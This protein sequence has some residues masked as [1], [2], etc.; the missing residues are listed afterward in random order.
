MTKYFII[1]SN[2]DDTKSR[3]YI[4]PEHASTL[5]RRAGIKVETEE[6]KQVSKEDE[7]L[8]GR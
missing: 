7:E 5:K 8:F 1:I 4:T 3:R 6:E 2:P